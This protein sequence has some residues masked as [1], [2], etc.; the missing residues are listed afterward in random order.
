MYVAFYA[1]LCA[2][3]EVSDVLLVR[4]VHQP[5]SQKPKVP[6]YLPKGKGNGWCPDKHLQTRMLYEKSRGTRMIGKIFFL[7]HVGSGERVTFSFR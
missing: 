4:S 5:M 7:W 1:K 2:S 3:P 6:V